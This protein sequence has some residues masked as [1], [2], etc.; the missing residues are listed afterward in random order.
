MFDDNESEFEVY[1][2]SEDESDEFSA[3]ASSSRENSDDEAQGC[4][5][6]G[7]RPCQRTARR[8]EAPLVWRMA[9]GTTPRDIPFTGNSGVQVQTEG[10]QPYD[11]FALFINND[12]LNCF[13]TET[14]RYAA[15]YLAENNLPRG[16]RANDWHPTDITEIKQFLGLFFLM[17]IVHKHGSLVLY[18]HLQCSYEQ[19]SFSVAPKVSPLQ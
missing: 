15:Q 17:G 18:A 10:F 14:N 5:D 2:A 11:L 12:L 4:G 7:N 13:A 19:K 6:D 8:Q 3:D 9:H 16:S 1:S